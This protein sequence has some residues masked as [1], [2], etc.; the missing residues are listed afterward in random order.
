MNFM[1]NKII[2]KIKIIAIIFQNF[3]NNNGYNKEII[4]LIKSIFNYL[5]Y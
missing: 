5:V 2:I 1:K 3:I 4:I